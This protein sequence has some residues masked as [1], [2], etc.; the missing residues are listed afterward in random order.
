MLKEDLVLASHLV[1]SKL[2]SYVQVKPTMFA[3]IC[4][5]LSELMTSTLP[6]CLNN[7]IHP[8]LK[9]VMDDEEEK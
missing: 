1:N 5:S 8:C 2:C 4:F 7:K 6:E 3:F 9:Y